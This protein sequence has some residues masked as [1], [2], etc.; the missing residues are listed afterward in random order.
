MLIVRTGRIENHVIIGVKPNILTQK[1]L[2]GVYLIFR[3]QEINTLG[4]LPR[5]LFGAAFCVSEPSF[6]DIY[7]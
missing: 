6:L 2:I 4:L 5:L 3:M 1:A 7:S